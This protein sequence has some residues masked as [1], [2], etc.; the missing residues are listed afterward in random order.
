MG[1]PRALYFPIQIHLQYKYNLN[2]NTYQT[3]T[4]WVKY[5]Y[6]I[7]ISKSSNTNMI[8]EQNK[9]R[10]Y[11]TDKIEQIQEGRDWKERTRAKILPLL[12]NLGCPMLTNQFQTQGIGQPTTGAL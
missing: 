5:K 4:N 11:N 6:S 10:K 12:S 8:W 7:D 1:P 3:I 9:C 2:T